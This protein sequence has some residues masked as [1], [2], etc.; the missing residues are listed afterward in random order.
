MSRK[1]SAATKGIML[2]L[3]YT[4]HFFCFP[5]WYVGGVSYPELQWMEGF[6]GHFQ[7]CIA[8]FTFLTGYFY[9]F[10]QKGTLRYIL[11]KWFD[12]LVPYWCVLAMLLAI[13]LF[14]GT[15]TSSVGAFILEMLGFKNAIMSF[16]W[17]VAYYLLMIPAL[18]FTVKH[19]KSDWLLSVIGV[20][21]PMVVYYG[22]A[23]FMPENVIISTLSKFQVYFPITIAGFMS[24]KYGIFGKID[25]LL[26]DKKL[27]KCTV[28][29]FMIGVVFMEPTWLYGNSINNIAFEMV[30]KVIRICSIPFFIYGIISVLKMIP[31]KVCR[32][33]EII[34]KY[35]TIMWFM[36]GIFFGCSKEIFQ[37]ILYAPTIPGL[38]LLWGLCLNLLV[39]VPVDC[40]AKW[41]RSKVKV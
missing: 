32:P 28:S 20:L 8:G 4:L 12:I 19:M 1:T 24:A 34:G 23:H 7:I 9:F 29:I 6:Q 36:H 21:L 18:V 31:D 5:S 25:E 26:R 17:Y 27:L 15:F 3:M 39:S 2:I 37:P 10:S 13:A 14:T 30:R 40:A 33:I 22:L 41:I 11:K 38:V 35:S 16:C